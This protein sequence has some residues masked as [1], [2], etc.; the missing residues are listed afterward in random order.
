MIKYSAMI[1]HKLRSPPHELHNIRYFAVILIF[2]KIVMKKN[3]SSN[4]FANTSSLKSIEEARAILAESSDD[5]IDFAAMKA[6]AQ[7]Q[8]QLSKPSINE[9]QTKSNIGEDD[10]DDIDA[11]DSNGEESDDEGVQAGS[12]KLH[13]GISS[14]LN[15]KTKIRPAKFLQKAH[16][17]DQVNRIYFSFA[18]VPDAPDLLADIFTSR[19][20]LCF[21]LQHRLFSAWSMKTK[22]P[23]PN[24]IMEQLYLLTFTAPDSVLAKEASRCAAHI[25][26][27]KQSN[28][29]PSYSQITD[30][31][32]FFGAESA[33]F[34]DSTLPPPSSPSSS[35]SLPPSNTASKWCLLSEWMTFLAA[36]YSAQIGSYPGWSED[37]SR[38]LYSLLVLSADLEVQTRHELSCYA[39]INSLVC[40][41][42]EDSCI[43]DRLE[44][45]F[46]SMAL[47]DETQLS[48]LSLSHMAS[49]FAV[50]QLSTTAGEIFVRKSFSRF[51]KQDVLP[52]AISVAQVEESASLLADVE[53]V[54]R[55]MA[56][57][58][59]SRKASEQQE[60]LEKMVPLYSFVS[61][62]YSL[63]AG[64]GNAWNIKTAKCMREACTEL[65]VAME[66]RLG[67]HVEEHVVACVLDLLALTDSILEKYITSKEQIW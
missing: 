19:N 23:V 64:S 30:A 43:D 5:E 59:S 58:C 53:S 47:K 6:K 40:V 41:L 55:A 37:L 3:E 61:L 48:T 35:S 57:A 44:C 4:L 27:E 52:Y 56:A 1:S 31:L 24:S 32:I 26:Q 62:S 38:S 45:L 2:Y 17:L 7:A 22:Q 63:C 29:L 9:I 49:F 60:L 11:D 65:K 28:W 51:R 20:D 39:A 16:H 14:E 13:S 50:E 18:T 34:L 33:V 54:M 25:Y 21:A 15:D 67:E 36:A 12:A 10:E 42:H 8:A 66:K 46:G